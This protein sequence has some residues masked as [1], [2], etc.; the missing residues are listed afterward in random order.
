MRGYIYA[1]TGRGNEAREVLRTLH[2]ASATRYVPPYA[3]ALVY[4]GLGEADA[5]IEW[6]SKA[7]D[8][9]DV[10]LLFLPVDPKW[11]PFRD[12]PRFQEIL[13]RCAFTGGRSSP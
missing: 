5:A 13:R 4:A 10:H 6:L 7:V 12:D 11:D 3:R 8:A 1:K 9:R 2:D